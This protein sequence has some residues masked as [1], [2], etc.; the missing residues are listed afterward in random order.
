MSQVALLDSPAAL[1]ALDRLTAA[2][3]AADMAAVFAAV[4]AYAGTVLA[5]RLCTAN[6]VD[7]DA[8]RVVRLYSSNPQAYPPG[9]SKEKAGTPWGQRVLRDHEIFVG[10]GVDAIRA[11]FDDHDAIARLGLQSVINVPVVQG[12]RCV[13]T[14]NFLMAHETVQASHVHMARLAAAMCVPAYLAAQG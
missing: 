10:E 8:M 1:A 5:H 3:A 9:G 6:R 13:G 7:V 4:D 14:L 12:G 2:H 11:F